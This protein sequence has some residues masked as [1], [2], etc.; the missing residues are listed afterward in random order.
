MDYAENAKY[1]VLEQT[2]K[3]SRESLRERLMRQKSQTSEH[4]AN[5]EKAIK[6][7]DEN[8]GFEEFHDL[9]GRVGY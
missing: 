5:I 8:K 1:G 6:F 9:V 2:P 4:L 7:L 3:L